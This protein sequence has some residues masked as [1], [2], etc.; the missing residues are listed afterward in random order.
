MTEVE[1]KQLWAAQSGLV[2]N[3]DCAVRT[4]EKMRKRRTIGTWAMAG[5]GLLALS[6]ALLRVGQLLVDPGYRL[7]NAGLELVLATIP[8]VGVFLTCRQ[9]L[10]DRREVD[11][12]T[13]D[14]RDCLAYLLA[15]TRREIREIRLGVPVLYGILAL[16][17]GAAKWQSIATGREA[18]ENEVAVI[19]FIIAILGT[20][21][22]LLYHRVM[23][24][25]RPRQAHLERLLE[26]LDG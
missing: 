3:A 22:A 15:R 25:L 17:V 20:A 1:L 23:A 19:I 11:A 4:I 16:V 8:L 2:A 13:M 24:V 5:A 10:H 21:G 14:S 26:Q 6:L 12:L 18:L 7:G 9:V